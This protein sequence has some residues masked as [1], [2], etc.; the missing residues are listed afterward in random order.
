MLIKLSRS[1][2]I[3]LAFGLTVGAAFAEE[4]TSLDRFDGGYFGAQAG[5]ATAG[6]DLAIAGMPIFD[7]NFSGGVIG[8]YGGY[9]WQRGRRYLGVEVSAGYSG[10]K[11]GNLLPVGAEWISGE[12]ERIYGFAILGKAGRVVGEEKKTLV[13]GLLGPSA[14]RVDARATLA[15]CGGV[16]DGALYPGL[17]VG[18]GVEHFFNDKFSSRVQAVYTRYYDVGNLIEEVS[19]EKYTSHSA[20]IQF[21]VTRWLGR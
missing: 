1:F 21:G 2:A 5:Y 10:V 4:P 8:L 18:V 11:D 16:S 13:Y 6:S 15:C 9:G 19:N 14:V 17:S 12:V 20:A 3:L 7:S